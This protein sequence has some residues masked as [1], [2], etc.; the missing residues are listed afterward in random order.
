MYKLYRHTVTI[1]DKARVFNFKYGVKYICQGE[2]GHHHWKEKCS[3]GLVHEVQGPLC[4]IP[5]V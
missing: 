5:N 4:I 3:A 2:N 1:L